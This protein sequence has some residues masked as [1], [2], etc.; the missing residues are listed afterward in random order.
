MIYQ[1]GMTKDNSN[2]IEVRLNAIIGLLSESL[3]SQD[4]ISINSVYQSLDR[5]GLSPKEIGTIFGKPG[6]DISST[7]S[8]IKK[9]KTKKEKKNESR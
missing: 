5:A 8:K 1:S 2:S 4:K 3:I 6:G 9:Q 7:M